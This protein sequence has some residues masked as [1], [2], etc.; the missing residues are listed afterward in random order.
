MLGPWFE[1][2]TQ[3][4][5]HLLQQMN[6]ALK[7]HSEVLLLKL[8]FQLFCVFDG[9]G[10]GIVI[11]IGVD[12]ASLFGVLLEP[13]GPVLQS[14]FRIVS[15]VSTCCAMKTN[16]YYIGCDYAGRFFAG[17]IVDAKADLQFFE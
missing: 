11:E 4:I 13:F 1:D 16:V 14:G 3:S 5:I 9:V 10:V 8:L 7:F 17:H 6:N 15:L 2:A 12:A